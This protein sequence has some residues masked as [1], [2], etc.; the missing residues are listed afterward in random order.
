MLLTF[1]FQLIRTHPGHSA[2]GL[3]PPCCG[4]VSVSKGSDQQTRRPAAGEGSWSAS[5][6][7][8]FPSLSQNWLSCALGSSV[9]TSVSTG[10]ISWAQKPAGF[11][12]RLGSR[13]PTTQPS[14]LRQAQ[15]RRAFA[16]TAG[17][18]VE[19]TGSS[20]LLP[21]E[22]SLRQTPR[23]ADDPESFL[24]NRTEPLLSL[25]STEPHE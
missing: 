4:S 10:L 17:S 20:V 3:R 6:V 22:V 5:P 13:P 9:V 14:L 1:L 18:P 23:V 19:L 16:L 21:L 2:P 11:T 15:R 24:S 25:P 7:Q 12:S 8:G